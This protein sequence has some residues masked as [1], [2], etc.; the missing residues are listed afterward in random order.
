MN[1]FL[2]FFFFFSLAFFFLTFWN[3]HSSHSFVSFLCNQECW[4]F[5]FVCL[6]WFIFKGKLFPHKE[7]DSSK[8]LQDSVALAEE[9]RITEWLRWEWT[10]WDHG[11][12]LQVTATEGREMCGKGECSLLQPVSG[13]VADAEHRGLGVWIAPQSSISSSR[14]PATF[15]TSWS[16]SRVKKFPVTWSHSIRIKKWSLPEMKGF[17]LALL[18]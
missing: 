9:C 8:A 2:I 13:V 18:R 15:G 16:S 10:T 14:Q 17:G 11:V 4:M 12:Q 5:L 7:A 1:R 3:I 6:F